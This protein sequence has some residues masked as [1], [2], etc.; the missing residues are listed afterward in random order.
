M[1]ANEV[2]REKREK[3]KVRKSVIK[4]RGKIEALRK[5]LQTCSKGAPAEPN[6]LSRTNN[7]PKPVPLFTRNQHNQFYIGLIFFR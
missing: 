2:G 1:T 4:K 7:T 6:R 5:K 3:K